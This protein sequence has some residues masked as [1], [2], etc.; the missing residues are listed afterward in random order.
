LK[1]SH[2]E[3]K[4]LL[5]KQ[6]VAREE[7]RKNISREMH[8]ELGQI[9][10]TLKIDVSLL[11]KRVNTSL[12]S[13]DI[14][15]EFDSIKQTIDQIMQS[16]K[17]IASGLR[18]E[19]IDDLGFVES[20]KIQC[21]EFEK[22]SGIRCLVSLPKSFQADK[23]FSLAIYRVVQ[24][25]LTNVL[26]HAKATRVDVK[27]REENQ[28]LSLEIRDNGVGITDGQATSSKSLGLIGLRERVD[29]LNGKFK[30]QGLKNRGTLISVKAPITHPNITHNDK[31]NNS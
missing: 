2:A 24:E 1:K 11:Q 16:V 9:L 20:I 15:S 7:E 31:H 8:D 3:L 29:I 28:T 14:S 27:I 4:S 19:T 22:K 18:P 12:A 30:I 6:Q 25:V 23:D 17:R 13:E 5:S 26:R 10:T 21:E